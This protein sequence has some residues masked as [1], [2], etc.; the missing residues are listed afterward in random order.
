MSVLA[1]TDNDEGLAEKIV[2]ELGS[3]VWE[4]RGQFTKK[5]ITPETAVKM[6]LESSEFPVLLAD[7]SDNPGGGA[8]AD[9]TQLLSEMIRQNVE[10]AAFALIADPES[11]ERAFSAGRGNLRQAVPGGKSRPGKPR[12]PIEAE[13]RVITLSDGRYTITGPMCT[14]LEVNM[15]KTAVVQIGGIDVIIC[16]LRTQPWDAEVFRKVGIEPASKKILCTLS[17]PPRASFEPIAAKIIRGGSS[18][19]GFK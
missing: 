10:N 7:T 6:A 17:L 13:G 14:G 11:A 18:R 2:T 1:V 3:R 19:A 9:G 16:T 5:F 8:P 15:G 12:A 4:R